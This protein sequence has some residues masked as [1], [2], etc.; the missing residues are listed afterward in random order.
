MTTKL[1]TE[2]PE[3]FEKVINDFIKDIKTSFPEYKIFIDKWWKEDSFFDYIQEEEQKKEAIKKNK[4]NR[5]KFI[6]NYC[7]KIST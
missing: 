3:E 4:E 5:I 1:K 2:I 6:F 7:L